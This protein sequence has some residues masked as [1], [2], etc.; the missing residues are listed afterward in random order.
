[1]PGTPLACASCGNRLAPNSVLAGVVSARTTPGRSVCA[2][3]CCWMIPRRGGNVLAPRDLRA[4]EPALFRFV[5]K[6][7]AVSHELCF[8]G[9][10]G[11]ARALTV[12]LTEAESGRTSTLPAVIYARTF[13]SCLFLCS[14]LHGNGRL[15][16]LL[17]LRV[18][19][20]DGDLNDGANARSYR[21]Q[22]F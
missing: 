7:K 2:R 17:L 3:G 13:R 1:M 11:V 8:V 15:C 6:G 21:W 22:A 4:C 16:L 12:G 18:F 20:H 5:L 14:Y 9:L 10:C 19:C